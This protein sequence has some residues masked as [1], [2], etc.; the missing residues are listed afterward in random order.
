MGGWPRSRQHDPDG[1]GWTFKLRQGVKF[2]DGTPF[3]AAA[4]CYNFDRWY[5][6]KGAAAQS[7]MIY[8]QDNFG[9]FAKNEAEGAGEALY[10][11]CEATDDGTAVVTLNQYKG[12]FPGA[13]ALTALSIAS[14]EA[15]K[16]CDANKVTQQ[17]DS[18]AYTAYATEHPVG[19]GPFKLDSTTRP[20]RRSRWCATT[21]TGAR[22]PRSR[23]WSSRSSRTRARAEAGAAGRQHRRLRPART[24]PTGRA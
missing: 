17:G 16:K 5:N 4:V 15:L 18:F 14:P 7:Q 23:R 20:T 3:N 22:R 2:H 6:M 8:Y 21:T 9:G 11:K 19:T 12:A 1:K 10:N 13:F 24:R